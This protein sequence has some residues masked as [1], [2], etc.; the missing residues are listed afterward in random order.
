MTILGITAASL[1]YTITSEGPY[2]TTTKEIK[3]YYLNDK[4]YS[5]IDKKLIYIENVAILNKYSFNN[6]SFIIKLVY[7]RGN[8]KNEFTNLYKDIIMDAKKWRHSYILVSEKYLK[9]NFK[10]K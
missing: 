5:S 3:V 9:E 2:I 10:L 8:D 1:N 7:I 6:D 4:L